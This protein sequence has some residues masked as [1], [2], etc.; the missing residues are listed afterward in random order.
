M[1]HEEE[2]IPSRIERSLREDRDEGVEHDEDVAND[3]AVAICMTLGGAIRTL[4]AHPPGGFKW[5]AFGEA[6][7]NACLVLQSS[8]TDRRVDF[9]I[10]PGKPE[11][12]YAVSID[13]ILTAQRTS[14]TVEDVALIRKFGEWVAGA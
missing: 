12:V 14:M 9:V 4:L 3:A 13:E 11:V 5:A 6:G 1:T 7:G 10:R 8:V 2:Q